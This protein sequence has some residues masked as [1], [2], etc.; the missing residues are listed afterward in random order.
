MKWW[1]GRA[2]ATPSLYNGKIEV[3]SRHCFFS[4]ISQHKQRFPSFSRGRCYENLLDT[5]DPAKANLTFW[6]D[7]AKG[8]DHFLQQ[9]TK[10][11]VLQTKAGSEAA[12][13]LHL[14]NHIET[15]SLHPETILYFVEDDYLH[16]AGWLDI[17]LEGM[18]LPGAHYVTLYD[19]C[20]KYFLPQYQSLTSKLFISPSCHWRTIP[21]TTQTFAVRWK[22]L[23]RDLPIHRRFSTGREITADHQKFTQLTRRGRTLVSSIPG[24]ST[25]AEPAFAS[26]CIDWEP[27]LTSRGTP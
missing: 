24:W 6:L 21:S 23:Q 9:E 12:S 18:Q 2:P 27:L 20:D 26:P 4:T 15:L 17:L 13:F 3:F 8:T 19:H 14:L 1:F 16:R 5:F 10:Y 22:Q 25:H 11:P 7:I